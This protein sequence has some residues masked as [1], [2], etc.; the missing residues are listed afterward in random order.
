MNITNVDRTIKGFLE[1]G[2][3]FKGVLHRAFEL[4]PAKVRD[5]IEA[6]KSVS[7]K[8]NVEFLVATIARQ[9]V[10]LG[11]IPVD[12]IS[13]ELLSDMEDTD[14]DIL[15]KAVQNL[16]KKRTEQLKNIKTLG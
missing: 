12:E 4:R 10:S 6:E 13:I 5:S 11:T 14:L 7:G 8:S 1:I 2:V 9:F 3:E 15:Q 16:K